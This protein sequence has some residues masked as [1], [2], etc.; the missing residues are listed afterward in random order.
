MKVKFKKKVIK[1]HVN[2][3]EIYDIPSCGHCPKEHLEEILY[4]RGAKLGYPGKLKLKSFNVRQC[5]YLVEFKSKFGHGEAW[6]E[7]NQLIF[8]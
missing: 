4:W 7:K 6:F 1:W 3:E 2:H 8:K 5:T